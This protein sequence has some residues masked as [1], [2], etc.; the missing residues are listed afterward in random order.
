M[1]WKSRKEFG[2]FE[3]VQTAMLAIGEMNSDI[4]TIQ[5]WSKREK[6]EKKY[7]CQF[8]QKRHYQF[9]NEGIEAE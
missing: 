8:M 2:K 5:I 7:E 6:I 4:N 9:V 3:S 1:K